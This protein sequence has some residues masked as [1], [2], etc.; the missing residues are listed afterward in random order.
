MTLGLEA[1]FE[2]PKK[3]ERTMLLM[4]QVHYKTSANTNAQ[5]GIGLESL[6]RDSYNPV[7]G[8]RLIYLF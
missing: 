8:M 1:D 2:L 5:F 6:E 7:M 4:P 3:D